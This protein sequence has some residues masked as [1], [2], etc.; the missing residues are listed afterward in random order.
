MGAESGQIRVCDEQTGNA[1]GFQCG[2]EVSVMCFLDWLRCLGWLKADKW[3]IWFMV[4]SSNREIRACDWL[5]RASPLP[6][7]TSTSPLADEHGWLCQRHLKTPTHTRGTWAVQVRY[8]ASDVD[9]DS[10][11]TPSGRRAAS[12]RR[13]PVMTLE[14]IVGVGACE[15]CRGRITKV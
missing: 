14:D 5:R 2:H 15:A 3:Y 12:L 10:N 11:P 1:A 8:L 7:S 9:M 6:T 13:P 4:G